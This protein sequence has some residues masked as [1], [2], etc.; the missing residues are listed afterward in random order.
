MNPVSELSPPRKAV[1]Y[2]GM[3]LGLVGILLFLSIFFLIFKGMPSSSSEEFFKNPTQTMDRDRKQSEDMFKS[4]GLRAGGGFFLIIAGAVTSAIAR[5]GEAGEMQEKILRQNWSVA[6]SSE[7][8][9]GKK[10]DVPPPMPV[11]KVR[12]RGCQALNDET[13]KFCSQ[14]GQAV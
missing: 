10:Q 5:K 13:A 7:K 6:P 8:G 9:A 4:F 2:V 14:C 1:Y 3:G 12:C 11:V